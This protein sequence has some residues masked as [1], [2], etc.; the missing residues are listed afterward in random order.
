M[1]CEKDR[2]SSVCPK[3]KEKIIQEQYFSDRMFF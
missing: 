3:A 2:A 1:P